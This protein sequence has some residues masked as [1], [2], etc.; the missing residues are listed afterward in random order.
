VQHIRA[1]DIDDNR[2]LTVLRTREPVFQDGCYRLN[3]YGRASVPSV[4]NFQL[5]SPRNTS[6]VLCQFGKFGEDEFHLDIKE[7]MSLIQAFAIA[8]CQFNNV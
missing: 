4:K 8:I 7:P 6:D 1:P 5:V 3:F 2:V